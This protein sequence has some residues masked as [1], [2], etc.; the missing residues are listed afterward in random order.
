MVLN[1][2]SQKVLSKLR[3]TFVGRFTWAFLDQILSS[4]SNFLVAIVIARILGPEQFGAFALAYA[5]WITL[6]GLN[7]SILIQPYVISV[8]PKSEKEW[9]TETSYAAT[10]ILI[11]GVGLGVLV[12]ILGL[13]LPIL[14]RD[15]MTTFVTLGVFCAPLLLQDFW[16]F[17]AFSR[18]KPRGAFIND[19]IWALT[20][21]FAIALMIF[22]QH[23]NAP[24]GVAV[25]ALGAT[26]GAVYGF[27]QFRVG[28]KFDGKLINWFKSAFAVG[29]W[30]GLS[31]GL[32]SLGSQVVLFF[33]AGMIGTAAVGGLRS[34][35]NLF[36]PAQLLA[37]S[38]ESIALPA[39]SQ[40][41]HT[42]GYTGVLYIAKRLAAM[43]GLFMAILA[44]ALTFSGGQLLV[45]VFGTA[46]LEYANLI[47][48]VAV[49][50]VA[51]AIM[52]GAV[53]SLR[54]TKS[55]KQ[56]TR[57]QVMV[58]SLKILGVVVLT[59]YFGLLGAAWGLTVAS[60]FHCIVLWYTVFRLKATQVLNVQK[61]PQ[62]PPITSV[63][64][65]V[66]E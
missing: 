44:L 22:L 62:E 49:M 16:R 35:H 13:M 25:W 41:L 39:A 58:T 19:A 61:F 18:S 63:G 26:A 29:G 27:W 24:L 17:A 51:G 60:V 10:T 31:N 38:A 59:Q 66:H 48:P 50:V 3:N 36:S 33:V 7:R 11:I 40:A 64:G 56:L 46:Y 34:I 20:T 57:A 30:F 45:F 53:L 21:T 9:V 2:L 65:A 6:M 23:L 54:A 37:V 32:Y 52:S 8:S 1:D 14:D 42:Q 4:G 15:A 28:L 47:P 12:S 55:G 43:L 5:T